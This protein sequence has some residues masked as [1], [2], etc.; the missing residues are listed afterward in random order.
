M[1]INFGRENGNGA[2]NTTQQQPNDSTLHSQEIVG[3]DIIE[4][5]NNL[6]FHVSDSLDGEGKV[7]LAEDT[8]ASAMLESHGDSDDKIERL[9]SLEE[10]RS[11]IDGDESDNAENANHSSN[12]SFLSTT[13]SDPS[14]WVPPVPLD[15]EDDMDSVAN[16]DDDEYYDGTKWGQSGNFSDFD[17]EHGS[18]F[19][20]ERQKAMME[21]MNGQF[22]I[23]VSRFLASED[24]SFSEGGHGEKWLDIV[25]SLSWEAALLIKP[26]A[27]EG[28]AMDPGSYVKV[29]CVASGARSQR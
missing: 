10:V 29:K 20:E 23:L 28:K 7:L 22:K 2:P 25:A 4:N 13:E 14:I 16:N 18:S 8:S 9:T 17:A 24:I 12:M 3:S 21:A 19:K 27:S 26:E 1:T 6:G 15:I 5:I 11:I